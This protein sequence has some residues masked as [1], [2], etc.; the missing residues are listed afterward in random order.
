MSKII[1]IHFAVLLSIPLATFLQDLNI[2]AYYRKDSIYARP[3]I[4]LHS[5]VIGVTIM[6]IAY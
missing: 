5:I 3:H 2:D 6:L 1:C 4:E